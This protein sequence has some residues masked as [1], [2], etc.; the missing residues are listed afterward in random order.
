MSVLF[1]RQVT[2]K[3]TYHAEHVSELKGT[4]LPELGEVTL[5]AIQSA[6]YD[7]AS[8]HVGVTVHNVLQVL[9]HADPSLR[10]KPPP[11]P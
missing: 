7:A 2:L 11:E 8:T 4:T 5:A 3:D 10:D 6:I 1:N 9:S